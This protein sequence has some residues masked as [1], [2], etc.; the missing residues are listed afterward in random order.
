VDPISW[1]ARS[2]RAFLKADA[3][4]GQWRDHQTITV[5]EEPGNDVTNIVPEGEEVKR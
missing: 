1:R 2:A 4:V 5:V 3:A